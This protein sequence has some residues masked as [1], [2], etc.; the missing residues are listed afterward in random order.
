MIET[1]QRA[2]T[3]VCSV[4]ITTPLLVLTDPATSVKIS[5]TDPVGTLVV[6]AATMTKDSVGVY[7]YD[8]T[9]AVDALLGTYKIKYTATDGTRV[10]IQNDTFLLE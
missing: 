1:F 2:E 9:P 8:Y 10:T 4:T 3:V 6:T 7:H 5:I